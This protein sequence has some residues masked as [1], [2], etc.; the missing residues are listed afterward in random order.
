MFFRHYVIKEHQGS[1]LVIIS[2]MLLICV[3]LLNPSGL[4]RLWSGCIDILLYTESMSWCG[5]AVQHLCAGA[6][7]YYWHNLEVGGLL[8]RGGV[9]HSLWYLLCR[10]YHIV[11]ILLELLEFH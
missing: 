8:D 1:H 7:G 11:R 5:V 9:L 10:T 3:I 4:S 2:S 6:A